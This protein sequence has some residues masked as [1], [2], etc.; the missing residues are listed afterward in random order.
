MGVTCLHR[1][2]TI[3]QTK[4]KSMAAQIPLPTAVAVGSKLLFSEL[5]PSSTQL[6]ADR[7]PDHPPSNSAEPWRLL[8][9]DFGS[10]R[11][12]CGICC[13]ATTCWTYRVDVM[14]CHAVVNTTAYLQSRVAHWRLTR[15]RF[16]GSLAIPDT[17][18]HVCQLS[19][20]RP[21]YA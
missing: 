1:N 13:A 20:L 3:T 8:C 21:A 4:S 12:K 18:A 7:Q 14:W 10:L 17:T 19:S 2:V 9:F 15:D 6:Q 5:Q 11:E 16:S